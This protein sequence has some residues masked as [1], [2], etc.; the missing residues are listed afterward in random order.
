[1]PPA[2]VVGTGLGGRSGQE[3]SRQSDRDSKMSGTTQACNPPVSDTRL[4]HY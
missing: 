3:G 1:M 4:V 2:A